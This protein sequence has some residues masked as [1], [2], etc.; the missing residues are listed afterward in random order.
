MIFKNDTTAHWNHRNL[1]IAIVLYWTFAIFSSEIESL[2][3]FPE[4][5]GVDAISVV[6]FLIVILCMITERGTMKIWQRIAAVP[7]AFLLHAALTIPASSALGVLKYAPDHVRTLGE[8]RAVFLI[9]SL[10]VLLLAMWRSRPF[11]KSEE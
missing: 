2:F 6:F 9:A 10:P 3:G 11:V 8:Q 7:V 5:D 4:G 1:W